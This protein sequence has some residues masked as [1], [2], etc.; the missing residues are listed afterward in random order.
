[1]FAFSSVDSSLLLP[2]SGRDPLGTQVVWQQRARD[3]VPALTAASRQPEGFQ[4]LLTALAWWPKFAVRY[5]RPQKDLRNFFLLV[6]QAFARACKMKGHEWPLPGS[7]RLND[8]QEPGLWI[9]L[10]PRRDFLL[11][12]P[13]ANGTWGIYRGPAINAA[14]IDELDQLRPVDASCVRQDTEVV[15]WLFAPIAQALQHPA[16][17]VSV[18]KK[19]STNVGK[20]AE[21]VERPPQKQLIRKVFVKPANAPLTRTLADLA[22]EDPEESIERLLA[23]ARKEAQ[24]FDG[25]LRDVESCERYI[26]CMDM[27][28]ERLA[29]HSGLRVDELAAKLAIDLR[30]LR[31]AKARFQNSGV[32]E[33]LAQERQSMLANAR[34]DSPRSLI[35]FLVAHHEVISAARGTAP[36]VFWGDTKRL[37]SVLTL[38]PREEEQLD[39]RRTW[40]NSYYLDALRHL[41]LR[42]GRSS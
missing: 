9:G 13:L 31:A 34:L 1:M 30:V 17:Q 4:V 42:T 39:A 33:G 15:Q 19:W 21:I 7:R 14:L 37:E 23:R 28:F 24:E 6:E 25:T 5:R 16:E 35:E 20:M 3:V 41:A 11:D 29:R 36:L 8:A 38:E 12:S 22:R 40:R 2:F 18:V 27:A 10:S 26:A 32:Y